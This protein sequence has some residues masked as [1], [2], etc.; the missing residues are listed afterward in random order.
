MPRVSPKSGLEAAIRW[1]FSSRDRKENDFND[2][3]GPALRKLGRLKTDEMYGFVP[4]IAMGGPSEV[5][6]LQKLKAVEHLVFLAQ[7]SELQVL[8]A[9]SSSG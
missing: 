4:A 9:H 6:Q 1:F 7:L 3:F 2:Y 8:K 5:K